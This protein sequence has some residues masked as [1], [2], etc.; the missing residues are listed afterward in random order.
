[1]QDKYHQLYAVS[2]KVRDLNEESPL[3][4]VVHGY[5]AN[6]YDQSPTAAVEVC[7]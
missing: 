4:V 2:P 3:V 5:G 1:M 7:R 6:G